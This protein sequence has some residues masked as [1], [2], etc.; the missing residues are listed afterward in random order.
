MTFQLGSS[1][2]D[3]CVLA[4]LE[5]EDAYGYSLTQEVQS[6]MNISESTL[7]PVLRR[8]QKADFLTTYD[9]PFQG[10][11]RRYYQ[12]TGLGHLRLLELLTEW[13]IYK[14][15]V[16]SVLLGGKLDG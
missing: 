16:D 8:L 4:I 13:K 15:K 9:Q 1:L 7:Y 14:E 12:I 11:N 3:A 6:V 10:R 2:L 5:K